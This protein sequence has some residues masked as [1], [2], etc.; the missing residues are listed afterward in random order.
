VIIRSIAT[1]AVNAAGIIV[2]LKFNILPFARVHQCDFVNTTRITKD[3]SK[4][5]GDISLSLELL[6]G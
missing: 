4:Q 5:E 6:R 2:A 3:T 1:L